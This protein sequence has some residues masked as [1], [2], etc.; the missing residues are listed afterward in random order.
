MPDNAA[1]VV[2]LTRPVAAAARFRAALGA[3]DGVRIIESPVLRIVPLSPEMPDGPFSGMIVTSEN[4][5]AALARLGV[6]KRP[7]WAVGG[8]TARAAA[9]AGYAARAADGD[10]E[11]LFALLC[12]DRPAGP[13]LHL[14]GTHARGNL[15]SRLS[16][17][18]IQTSEIVVYDQLEL[19]L[20]A[21]ARAALRGA[22]PVVLP[23][24]SPR[25]AALLAAELRL[26]P[27]VH[28][29]AISAAAA[30]PFAGRGAATVSVAAVPDAAAMVAVTLAAI[31]RTLM[32]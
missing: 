9:D 12:R 27:N 31:R 24:F 10:A 21:P 8:H 25:S 17:Q 18:G 5:A 23:V 28:V 1:P 13:L 14:R 30:A 6:P 29:V 19:P 4:G 7:V 15:A 2:I 26:G 32:G 16:E 3:M 20:T 22:T 11:S